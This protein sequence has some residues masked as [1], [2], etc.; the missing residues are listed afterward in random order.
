MGAAAKLGAEGGEII[1][2]LHQAHLLAIFLVEEGDSALIQGLA[3]GDYL[4]GHLQI[5]AYGIVHDTLYFS[6][7]RLSE[8]CGMAEIEAEAIGSH[9]RAGLIDVSA[10]YLSQCRL[11]QMG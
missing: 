5:S 2:D 4:G 6:K 1:R 8:G 10:Q 11:Q 9:P 3:V 7:L